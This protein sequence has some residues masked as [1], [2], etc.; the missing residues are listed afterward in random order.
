MIVTGAFTLKGDEDNVIIEYC[1]KLTEYNIAPTT[2]V[3]K[4]EDESV[5][6]ANGWTSTPSSVSVINPYLWESQRKKE[7]VNGLF[8][9]RLFLKILLDKEK[10]VLN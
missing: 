5:D 9:R 6:T 7:K 2:P 10:K 1:Y 4:D 8:G 3:S